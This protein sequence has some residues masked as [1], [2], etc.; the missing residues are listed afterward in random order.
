M[1]TEGAAETADTASAEHTE[2]EPERDESNMSTDAVTE[3]ESRDVKTDIADPIPQTA[4]SSPHPTDPLAATEG[5]EV[6]DTQAHTPPSPP[7]SDGEEV[8]SKKPK[9][10]APPPSIPEV[11]YRA[12]WTP[13]CERAV[14]IDRIKG[15]LYGNALGDAMGLATEFMDK[16]EV[17][18][19]YKGSGPIPFQD[20]VSDFHR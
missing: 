18:K 16:L 20:I 17:K 9:T 6:G 1:A 13:K 12:D 2:P 11:L 5:A 19:Y 8:A 3:E 10:D 14:V 15:C 7:T 4:D